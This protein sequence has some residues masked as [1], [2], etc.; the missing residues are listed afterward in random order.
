LKIYKKNVRNKKRINILSIK[1]QTTRQSLEDLYQILSFLKLDDH[2]YTHA[3][4][5][6]EEGFFI[7]KFGLRFEEVRSENLIEI[8]RSVEENTNETGFRIH[9]AIYSK[10]IDINSIIHIHTPEI[11]AVSCNPNGLKWYS[12]SAIHLYENISY[13]K[14]DGLTL[15]SEQES[16]IIDSIGD[17]N[18]L[19]LV[20]H[21]A[22]VCGKTI[23]EA[24]FYTYHLQQACRT[25]CLCVHDSIEPSHRVCSKARD[26]IINFEKN[27]GE[28]DW[29]AWI[30][31]IRKI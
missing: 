22:V 19:L 23:Q 7:N 9:G 26:N 4:A 21:G 1:I 10:R 13:L 11:V 15:D 12:Q 24:M 30:R 28:R 6:S 16:N 2:T 18:V 3:S 31:K 14:Y 25:Q 20:N 17:K 27:L 8:K 29:N 5:R